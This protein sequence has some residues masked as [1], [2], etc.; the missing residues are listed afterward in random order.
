MSRDSNATPLIGLDAVV[1]DTETTGLDAAKA[2]VVEIAV[3]PITAGQVDGAAAFRALVRPDEPIP[4][5]ATRIHGIDEAALAGARS[6]AEIWPSCAAAIGDRI[7]IGH[8]LGFDLAVLKREC[9]RA[10][11]AWKRPR[12]LDTRLL[13]EVARADL[14]GYSLDQLAAWLGVTMN[15]RHSA[16]GDATITAHLFLALLPKLRR[17]GIRTLGEAQQASRGL[18]D[19]LE[20]QHRAGWLEPVEAPSRR[21]AERSLARIDSYPYRHRVSSVMSAPPRFVAAGTTVAEALAIMARERISS[22]FVASSPA[23]G[24]TH[25]T[26]II[27]ERDVLRALSAR[28]NAALAAPVSEMMS[29]PLISVPADAFV[30]RAIGRMSRLKIRHLGVVDEDGRVVGALS[31]RDLLRL[32][33]EEAVSLGDEIDM[34]EHAPDLARAWA[35][36]P[37]VARGLLAEGVHGFDVAAVISRELGALTREAAIIA[38]QRMQREGRGGAPCAYAFAVLGSAGRGESLLALDQDNALVFAEGEPG[39]S[40]DQ[41]FAALATHV[42]DILHEVGVPYCSGGVMA[43]NPQWRGS[44]ATWRERVADWIRRSD[45]SDLMS[46]D[47]FFDLRAVHGDVRLATALWREGFALAHGEVGFAKLLAEAAGKTEPGLNLFG[48]I[49]TQGGRID[50]KKA[51]L[52]GI[53]TLARLLAIRHHVVERATPARLAG[54]RALGIGADRDLDALVEAQRAFFELILDQQLDDIEHGLP[55]TNLVVV[56][57]LT[58]RD[59]DRL[60]AGLEAVQHLD[61]LGRDLLFR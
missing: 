32:R 39:G 41:W 3:V 42:A 55:A 9:E 43:S 49:R 24:R 22:L 48:R 6:F 56:K 1:L 57:R 19:V 14:A 18:T 30:Y 5:A 44:V 27:T 40:A 61:D 38:E 59:H 31:A 25:D 29:R 15:G 52:F 21:D 51:G 33:A 11:I 28:G 54:I 12:A 7:V 47:I 46:V 45:P 8:T 20:E 23:S 53:V 4:Q 26:G 37:L 36:L 50:L 58:R 13:A 2:R 10:D 17:H 60:H 34:A 35:K 16:L